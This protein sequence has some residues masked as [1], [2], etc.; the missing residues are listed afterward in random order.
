MAVAL[1]RVDWERALGE[2]RRLAQAKG[3]DVS[4]R[5]LADASSLSALFEGDFRV[6]AARIGAHAGEPGAL[7][8]LAEV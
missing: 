8:H 7:E 5:H 2:L 4:R 1:E 6:G 3:G